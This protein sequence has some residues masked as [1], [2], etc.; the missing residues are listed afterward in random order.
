MSHEI[1]GV[2]K[3]YNEDV[4]SNVGRCPVMLLHTELPSYTNHNGSIK[5]SVD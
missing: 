5:N 3:Q 2:A 4:T 1:S